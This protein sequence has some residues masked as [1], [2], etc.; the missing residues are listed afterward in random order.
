[1]EKTTPFCSSPAS[2]FESLGAM[3]GGDLVSIGAV[4]DDDVLSVSEPSTLWLSSLSS[5]S[6]SSSLL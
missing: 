3:A 4:D 2:S 1:M 5:S 6:L